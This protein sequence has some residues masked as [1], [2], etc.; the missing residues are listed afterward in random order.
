[1]SALS[2]HDLGIL[3]LILESLNSKLNYCDSCTE[4]RE[5]KAYNVHGDTF[6]WCADCNEET[7]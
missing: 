3:S 2:E 4:E 7:P 5:V 1:M 6:Y